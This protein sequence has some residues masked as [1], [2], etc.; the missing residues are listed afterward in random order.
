MS[1]PDWIQAAITCG[2]SFLGN[3]FVYDIAYRRGR[4][5]GMLDEMRRQ[6]QRA[7][8]ELTRA[9]ADHRIYLTEPLEA[10]RDSEPPPPPTH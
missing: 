6:D 7:V 9:L 5:R 3:L 8:D 4:T 10:R 2:V 1:A